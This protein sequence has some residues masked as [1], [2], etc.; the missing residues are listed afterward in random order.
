M[1]SFNNI[2]NVVDE[3]N[4]DIAGMLG[5]K[6]EEVGIV[7]GQNDIALYHTFPVILITIYNSSLI[8]RVM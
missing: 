3:A 6:T 5:V 7:L 1:Q 8:S 4:A 2:I